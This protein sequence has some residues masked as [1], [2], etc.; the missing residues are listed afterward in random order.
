MVVRGDSGDKSFLVAFWLWLVESVGASQP[1][2]SSINQS[3]NQSKLVYFTVHKCMPKNLQGYLGN[4]VPFL[5][6]ED[7]GLLL[8]KI[9]ICNEKC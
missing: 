9:W 7:N 6:R 1:L 2:A 8:A 3:I 5:K 4:K